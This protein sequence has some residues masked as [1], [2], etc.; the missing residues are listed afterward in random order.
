M[1]TSVWSRPKKAS[2][3]HKLPSDSLQVVRS[4]ILR[5]HDHFRC[6][7]KQEYI[8]K[9]QGGW[10]LG[11]NARAAFVGTSLAPDSAPCLHSFAP[12]PRGSSAGAQEA[13]VQ[14]RRPAPL[15]IESLVLWQV[16][17]QQ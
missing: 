6:G 16:V 11:L 13:G 15:R 9:T 4:C 3:E 14:P 2:V 8:M 17:V 10:K 7:L 5:H 1:P 12:T